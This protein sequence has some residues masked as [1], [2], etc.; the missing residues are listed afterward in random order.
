MKTNRLFQLT[1]SLSLLVGCNTTTPPK[2]DEIM[3]L[4]QKVADSQMERFD[5]HTE[6]KK[7]YHDLDWQPAIFYIGLNELTTINDESRYIDWLIA[8]GK[9]LK[10]KLRPNA[11][12]A[13][14]Q[15]IGQF[16]LNMAKNFSVTSSAIDPT[17]K[18]FDSI[19]KSE[20]SSEWQW[21]HCEALFMAPT[22]WARLSRQTG[23]PKY[24]EYMDRQYRLS[25]NQLYNSDDKLFFSELNKIGKSEENGKA[26]YCS[27][28]NG[29]VFGGLAMM[30]AELPSDWEGR[31]FYVTLFKEM[32][33]VTTHAP[34]IQQQRVKPLVDLDR[35]F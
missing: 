17:K 26:Q 4:I 14:E 10:W 22:G 19:I 25:Y 2:A 5:N 20:N 24:L 6:D 28:G 34:T 33:E 32:A 3:S 16:Y 35:T 7:Q 13:E 31:G 23:D 8:K 15:C 1:I 11:E 29:L 18:Q 27:L 21:D 30:I 12:S 9:K